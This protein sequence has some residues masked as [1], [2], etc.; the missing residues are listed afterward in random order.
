MM[1]GTIR[2]MRQRF[3]HC[4]AICHT[5]PIRNAIVSVITGHT[6]VVA[7]LNWSGYIPLSVPIAA[8]VAVKHYPLVV[9][10]C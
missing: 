5:V 6:T 1:E 10:I 4:G 8:I 3:V 2:G 7:R 9:I